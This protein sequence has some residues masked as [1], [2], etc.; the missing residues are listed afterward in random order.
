MASYKDLGIPVSDSI[1]EV[2][3]FNNAP[4][5]MSF[6]RAENF[7]HLVLPGRERLSAAAFFSFLIDH[8]ILKR[9]I[10][11]DLGPRKD[12]ENLVPALAEALNTDPL[13]NLPLEKDI[14][15]LLAAGN[16]ALDG[17]NTV[18]WRSGLSLILVFRSY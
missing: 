15:D 10:M 13:T 4:T 18:I 12:I 11:F 14:V 16:I 8:P 1:V 17:I 2:K 6:I 5:S 3:V 9:R 7:I